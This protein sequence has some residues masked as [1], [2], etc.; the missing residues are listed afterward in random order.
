VYMSKQEGIWLLT[1]RYNDGR[2]TFSEHA[3]F[4]DALKEALEASAKCKEE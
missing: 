2:F 4:A 1:I 3:T